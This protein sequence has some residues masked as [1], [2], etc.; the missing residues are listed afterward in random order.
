MKNQTTMN[1]LLF[2]GDTFVG[3]DQKNILAGSAPYITTKTGSTDTQKRAF[4]SLSNMNGE[5][6]G[7]VM[8]SASVSTIRAG[9]RQILIHFLIILMI[10]LFIGK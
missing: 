1:K 8:V 10:V 6:T 2:F 3:G 4:H 9:Q 5:I 7:F